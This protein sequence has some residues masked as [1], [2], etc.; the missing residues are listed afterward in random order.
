[1]GR[2]KTQAVALLFCLAA[3]CFAWWLRGREAAVPVQGVVAGSTAPF[4]SI[5]LFYTAVAA[6]DWAQVQELTTPALW[7][8]LKTSGFV[9]EWEERRRADP[10]VAFRLFLVRASTVDWAR[11]SAWALGEVQWT[12]GAARP[13]NTLQTVFLQQISNHWHLT[14]IDS[15]AAVEVTLEFYQAI[16]SGDWFAMRRLTTPDY[17]GRLVASGVLAALQR[18]WAASATGVYLVVHLRD[19]VQGARKAWVS[20]DVLWR[21]LTLYERETPVVVELE[22]TAAG[23]Q[24]ARVHGHWEEAK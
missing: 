17:W 23:W 3:A 7:S 24:V 21:P 4:E 5:D 20:A 8:Y 2:R 22:K 15:R 6:N 9:Q 19:F 13:P 18:E 16:E 1:M 11:G 12:G 14:R 10:T